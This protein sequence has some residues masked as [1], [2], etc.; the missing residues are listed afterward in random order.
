MPIFERFIVAYQV[1]RNSYL[2]NFGLLFRIT[3]FLTILD[4]DLP[5]QANNQ[6]G[7]YSSQALC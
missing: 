4:P 2:A 3:F 7:G 1:H 6:E 5:L